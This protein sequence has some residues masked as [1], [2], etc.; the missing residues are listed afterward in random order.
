MAIQ[1]RITAS[2]TL[3]GASSALPVTLS[4][5]D[6]I[7]ARVASILPNGQVRLAT[8]LGTTDVST[9]VPLSPGSTVKLLVQ[10]V[11][12]QL[13]L[14]LIESTG[15]SGGNAAGAAAA[16]AYGSSFTGSQQVL[17]DVLQA[18]LP[19]QA[20]PAALFA[21]LKSVVDIA[22]RSLPA[23][24]TAAARDVL[25]H[26]IDGQGPVSADAVKQAVIGSGVFRETRLAA[27]DTAA[28]LPTED[29]K[30]ALLVLRSTLSA[31]AAA[32]PAAVEAGSDPAAAGALSSPS[33]GG[34]AVGNVGEAV[35]AASTRVGLSGAPAGVTGASGSVDQ[36]TG[37]PAVL[38]EALARLP[39]AGREAALQAIRAAYD[40]GDPELARVLA[41]AGFA[42]PA[43]NPD[44]GSEASPGAAAPAPGGS[45]DPGLPGE[46]GR[47]LQPA[48][49][50]RID[51][52]PRTEDPSG[53]TLRT[54]MSQGEAVR[55]LLDQTDATLDRVRLSQYGALHQDDPA[56]ATAATRDAPAWIFDVPVLQGREATSA[57][58]RISRDGRNQAGDAAGRRWS[59]EFA[60][61]ATAT[62]PIHAE[63]RLWGRHV[64]V[65]LWA[66]RTETVRLLKD[67]ASVLHDALGQAELEV[68]DVAVLVGSPQP[69]QAEQGYFVDTRS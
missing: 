7:E 23:G 25:T 68:E 48:S 15:A 36:A 11:G 51:L 39:A 50:P 20:G 38:T 34:T 40:P 44:Q 37:L 8:S 59:V 35:G 12:A 46:Q 16:R 56:Q 64:G 19:N 29:L 57:Q 17:A 13:T 55:L 14:A 69:P 31:V 10:T 54:G 32:L 53:P 45:D 27:G 49:I 21:N 52:P 4:D 65:T 26:A 22:G 28:A 60:L 63:I 2:T 42:T 1:S 47:R 3:P 30:S 24:I 41:K 18:A 9:S 62:G 58:V 5:G 66:E 33:A 67:Q 43:G 61:D 6:V